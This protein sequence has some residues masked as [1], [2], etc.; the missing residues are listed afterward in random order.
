MSTMNSLVWLLPV[1]FIFHDFEEIIFIPPWLLRN[2]E[3]IEK[4]HVKNKRVPFDFFVSNGSTALCIYEEFIILSVTTFLSCIFNNYIVWYGLFVAFTIHLVIHLL[5]VAMQ[6]RYVPGLT[7]SAIVLIP[8]IYV[9]YISAIMT[10][11]TWYVLSLSGV[12]VF[13][14]M[15]INLILLHKSV[16][17][18]DGWLSKFSGE[19]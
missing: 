17:I 1:L 6:H 19:K 13:A 5:F 11:Y 7:T 12:L 3:Y 18:F 10:S 15:I 9:L 4:A 14:F 2:K 16:K 8:S